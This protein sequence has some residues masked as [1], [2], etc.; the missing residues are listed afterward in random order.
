M[1]GNLYGSSNFAG[2]SQNNREVTAGGPPASNNTGLPGGLAGIADQE[3]DQLALGTQTPMPFVLGFGIDLSNGNYIVDQN[4]LNIVEH[5]IK[6]KTYD[7]GDIKELQD[8]TIFE[9]LPVPSVMP[10]N[11]PVSGK[12]YVAN[13]SRVL[14]FGGVTDSD[15]D[16]SIESTTEWST[17]QW[18]TRHKW[19][20]DFT[21][22]PTYL[23]FT[24]DPPI[25]YTTNTVSHYDENNNPVMVNSSDITWKLD[26]KEVHKGWYLELGALS[27]T[28]EI[29]GGQTVMIPRIIRC[30]IANKAG[31]IAEEI[32]YACVDSDSSSALAG[33]N[34]VDNFTAN[35]EG[36]FVIAP[37]AKSVTFEPDLRYGPREMFGRFKWRE[38]GEGESPV[39][40]FKNRK[41]KVEVDGI[42]VFNDEPIKLDG[43]RSG[44]GEFINDI[45]APVAAV[46][47]SLAG[48]AIGLIFTGL[49]GG[50]GYGLFALTSGAILANAGKFADI[51]RD[52]GTVLD[53]SRPL[54]ERGVTDWTEGRS[55][56]LLYT[57]E[58]DDEWNQMIA[59]VKKP[60]PFTIDVKY[61]FTYRKG[62]LN[63]GKKYRR[64][65]KFSKFYSGEFFN[66]DVPLQGIDIGVIQ[67]PY[68]DER[69]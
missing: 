32:K 66:L 37:E 27:E 44:F 13:W 9:L 3:R 29:I 10:M 45:L 5:Y 60:G 41:C 28:V 55:S 2:Q 7:R 18:A 53:D 58:D 4:K 20:R 31:I 59:F 24:G 62:F 23:F 12:L 25:F 47:G 8:D 30:E 50:L 48:L 26:G 68:S 46:G 34:E 35:F 42:T 65:Y 52:D 54:G 67:I 39:R 36:R 64:T 17:E 43:K 61:S 15:K 63:M 21:L 33:V 22:D 57:T 56:A 51:F 1:A 16:P 69:V 19:P 40:K 38:L 11:P 14:D 6:N 49:T